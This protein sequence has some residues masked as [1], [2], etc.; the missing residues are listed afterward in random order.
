M[1][2]IYEGR[3]LWANQVPYV[4]SDTIPIIVGYITRML[5]VAELRAN[6]GLLADVSVVEA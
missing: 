6:F 5:F 3:S 2:T 1:G 4:E